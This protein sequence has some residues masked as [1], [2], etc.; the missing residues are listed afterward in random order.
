MTNVLMVIKPYWYQGT[1]VFDDEAV[2][3]KKEPFVLGVPEMLDKM[4]K[5]IPNARKGFRLTFSALPFPSYQQELT[6]VREERCGGWYRL[7]GHTGEG[8]LCSAMFRYFDTAPEKIYA[9]ADKL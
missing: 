7:E 8:W 5:D 4:V 6:W 1:W 9:R 3:L 2:G